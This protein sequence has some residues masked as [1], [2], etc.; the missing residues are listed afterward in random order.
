MNQKAS[1]S[2]TEKQTIG[3][4]SVKWKASGKTIE[5]FDGGSLK[6]GFLIRFNFENIL[7]ILGKFKMYYRHIIENLRIAL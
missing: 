2:T 4:S 7:R 1:S 6:K 3:Y 5:T